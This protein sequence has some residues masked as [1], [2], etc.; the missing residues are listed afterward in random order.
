VLVADQPVGR[1]ARLEGA[2]EPSAEEHEGEA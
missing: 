1:A 2:P